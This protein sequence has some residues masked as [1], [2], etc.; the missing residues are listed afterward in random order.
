LVLTGA[1][2]YAGGTTISGGILQI[3]NG[4]TTGSIVG[5]V[6]DNATLAFNRSDTVTYGGVVS[7]SGSLTKAGAGTLVLTGANTYAGGTTISSGI[8][9]IGN[10][11]T[12]GSIVGNIVDN[13]ALVFN[14]SDSLIYGGIVSGTGSLTKMGAGT[15]VLTGANTYSGGTFV[16]SGILEL[17]GSVASIVNVAAAG[18]LSGTGTV[19]GGIANAGVIAPGTAANP[20][21]TLTAT[22]NVT[23]S[24]GSFLQPTI[25]GAGTSSLLQAGS[26]TITAGQVRPQTTGSSLF[27][28]QTDYRI[29]LGTAGLAGTFTGVDESLLPTFLDASLSYTGTEAFLR[30]RRNATNFAATAGLTPNQAA[31]AGSLD[32]AVTASNPLAYTTY[33]PIYN[34]LLSAPSSASLQQNLTTLSGDG[35][36]AFQI[37]AQG[38]ADR[39]GERL[40]AHTWSNSSNLWGSV[41]YGSQDGDS[42]GNGPG[43][44]SKGAEFQIGFATSLGKD[45]RVGV[46]AGLTKDDVDVDGRA[47][48]GN[49]ETWSVGVQLRQDFGRAYFAGQATYNWHNIDTSRA[50]ML[51]GTAAGDFDAQT[52]TASG[53]IGGVF[54]TGRL[55]L[56]PFVSLRHAS[57]HQEAYS[58][59][60]PAGALNVDSARYETTRLGGGFRV[61]NRD[62][63]SAVR[64]YAMVTYEREL[65]D[66]SAA[67]DNNLPGLPGF[68]VSSTK[69]GKDV[70]SAAI[71]IEV[72]L[73]GGVSLF[74]AG[75]GRWRDNEKSLHGN[76]GLRIRF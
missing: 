46:S 66:Q 61:I 27:L 72:R 12:T 18:R 13:A 1:N 57:T 21:G 2:T 24:A 55:N 52:W 59:T 39:F 47:T 25:S 69:L 35:L 60:G 23:F 41:A 26:I 49:V 65:G 32:A 36:T 64:P 43:Y 8:L 68:R 58:E 20:F 48:T 10:G 63:D 51:G 14:R 71:G 29:A 16:T 70:L 62:P 50:L 5:N 44:Q 67:L 3:G 75:G 9:Q 37:A 40:E 42:D 7:G 4:G 74:A 31:I 6:V 30:V 11:G 53:E 28:M 54:R 19:N 56:E 15:L 45:T 76:G 17:N 22:G 38:A 33:A 73:S 34:A